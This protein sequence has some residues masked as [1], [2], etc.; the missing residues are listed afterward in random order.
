MN[1]LAGMIECPNQG[2]QF[3]ALAYSSVSLLCQKIP[4]V[5]E[6]VLGEAQLK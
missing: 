4:E 1:Y 3:S 6:L 2:L 5:E